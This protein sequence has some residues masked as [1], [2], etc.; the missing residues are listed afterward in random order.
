MHI[1]IPSEIMNALKGHCDVLQDVEQGNQGV[2]EYEI[3]GAPVLLPDADYWKTGSYEVWWPVSYTMPVINKTAMQ[4]MHV[5]PNGL[6]VYMDDISVENY[7]N[8]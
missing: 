6:I 4:W 3:L 8:G 5:Q 7:T 2:G 1:S